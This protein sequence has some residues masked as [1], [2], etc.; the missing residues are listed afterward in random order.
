M[1]A[2][3]SLVAMPELKECLAR[4]QAH[5]VSSWSPQSS[6]GVWRATRGGTPH[7]PP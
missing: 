6:A 1:Y 3:L 4:L 7:G 5:P 2:P